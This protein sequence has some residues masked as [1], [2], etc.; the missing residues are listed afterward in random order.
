MLSDT[1]IA[2]VKRSLGDFTYTL[3]PSPLSFWTAI[4]GKVRKMA[5][6]GNSFPIDALMQG[7]YSSGGM[8]FLV[9][10][11]AAVN[12]AAT[13]EQ[14][15]PKGNHLALPRK[16]TLMS[17]LAFLS[18]SLGRFNLTLRL[19]AAFH[20]LG[21]MYLTTSLKTI[22]NGVTGTLTDTGSLLNNV[23][24]VVQNLVS[25]LKVDV[26]AAIDMVT[27]AINMQVLDQSIFPA[28]LTMIN[29]LYS[30]ATDQQLILG[31]ST[32]VAYD[33]DLLKNDTIVLL[34]TTNAILAA[35]NL[36]N[37][38]QQV[39]GYPGYNWTVKQQISTSGIDATSINNQAQSA[40]DTSS[41][42]SALNTAPNLANYANEANSTLYAAKTSAYNLIASTKATFKN[43]SVS[44]LDGVQTM[45]N[46]AFTPIQTQVLTQLSGYQTQANSMFAM[47]NGYDAYRGYGQLALVLVYA[48]PILFIYTFGA[49]RKPALM[50]CCNLLCI[51]YYALLFIFAIIFVLITFVLGDACDL[52]FDYTGN[53]SPLAAVQP[54]IGI[55]L[56]AVSQCYQNQSLFTVIGN[57]GLVN[58]DQLNFTKQASTVINSFNFSQINNFNINGVIN[59][60]QNPTSQIS[61]ISNLNV[62]A[63]NTSALDNIHNVLVTPL[64]NSLTQLSSTISLI[65]VGQAGINVTGSAVNQTIVNQAAIDFANQ[66]N[67]IVTQINSITNNT[68]GVLTTVDSNSALLS[69][70]IANL[71]TS[72]TSLI[73]HALTIPMYYN[74][75]VSNITTFATA[76]QT[77]ITNE[78]P[79][80]IDFILSAVG[81]Q[82][83]YLSDSFPCNVIASDVYQ[84]RQ[85]LCGGIVPSFDAFWSSLTIMALWSV[86][87]LPIIVFVAN[88]LFLDLTPYQNKD[89]QYEED[90]IGKDK[91][92]KLDVKTKGAEGPPPSVFAQDTREYVS[93]L[94]DAPVS[95]IENKPSEI[96]SLDRESQKVERDSPFM[97]ELL[98]ITPE[99]PTL[100]Q[101]QGEITAE[102]ALIPI[103]ADIENKMPIVE[104]FIEINDREVEL[105]ESVVVPKPQEEPVQVPVEEEQ[106]ESVD[107][108]DNEDII[109][110]PED[111]PGVTDLS[112]VVEDD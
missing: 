19:C 10:V 86:F 90:D 83:Q 29:V 25:N 17:C 13:L 110:I 89:K 18:L 55:A 97:A 80:V 101:Q 22:E 38:Q 58:K 30:C 75:S 39:T 96:P 91:L 112:E 64:N 76:V 59:L 100:E 3:P 84:I 107:E 81:A 27:N 40:P 23:P 14:S 24:S 95:P 44:S 106:E 45:V 87:S 70:A 61:A 69:A 88:N 103:T 79:L 46:Q 9:A 43:T 49:F 16:S 105:K 78:I 77:N 108:D 68:N 8:Y 62:S 60:S 56:T 99:E 94:S 57:T 63:L 52:A 15:M 73:N 5:V 34:A 37:S 28:M 47:V 72:A 32:I 111:R 26:G 66:L 51:P 67:S 74:Y 7:N 104:S 53:T 6:M 65:P 35:V 11:C 1:S 102:D 31:N 4:F 20:I 2:L 54:T 36:L 42:F 92:E 93:P 85:G 48:L 71:K 109:D 41:I 12:A 82:Q 50:K 33:T 98:K 21:S